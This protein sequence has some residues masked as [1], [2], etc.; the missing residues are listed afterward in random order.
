MHEELVRLARQQL[1]NCLGVDGDAPP[2][3]L[4]DD[5]ANTFG[6]TSLNKVLFI[7]ALCDVARVD[8]GRLTEEDLDSMRTLGDVVRILAATETVEDV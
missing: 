3:N 4:D 5:M 8:I 1:A 2:M 7:T 6:L